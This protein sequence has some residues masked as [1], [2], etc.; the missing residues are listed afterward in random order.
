MLLQ[1]VVEILLDAVERAIHVLRKRIPI[2]RCVILDV[3]DLRRQ[4]CAARL[5]CRERVPRLLIGLGLELL[6]LDIE[7]REAI[8]D[9][10]RV[11]VL[12]SLDIGVRHRGV[13]LG[14][15]QIVRRRLLVGERL[16]EILLLI[17]RVLLGL[18]HFGRSGAGVVLLLVASTRSKRGRENRCPQ[19]RTHGSLLHLVRDGLQRRCRHGDLRKFTRYGRG[20][21][22]R[23][24]ESSTTSACARGFA[25]FARSCRRS[26]G[27][28]GSERSSIARGRSSFRFSRSIS[29]MPSASRWPRPARSSACSARVAYVPRSSAECSPIVSAARSR[30]SARCSAVRSRWWC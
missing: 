26:I 27:P 20:T 30:W 5:H 3:V 8:L 23:R 24:A 25:S 13:A 28:F 11:L 14:L 1:R 12:R 19:N 7:L 29:R 9:G 17:G 15:F 4:R 22:A 16:V 2:R 18:L 6:D 21:R 10:D